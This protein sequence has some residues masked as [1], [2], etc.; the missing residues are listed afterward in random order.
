VRTLGPAF[1]IALAA[2]AALAFVAERRASAQRTRAVKEQALALGEVLRGAALE[3]DQALGGAEA[4]LAGRLGA[5]ARRAETLLQQGR[6]P[7]ADALQRVAK[8]ERVGRIALL[9]DRGQVTALVRHP[10]LPPAPGADLALR[11]RAHAL[12]REDLAAAARELAPPPG[13]V[14]TEGLAS[15]RLAAR[16]RFG[17]AYGR[18]DGGTLLLRADADE[19]AELRRRFGLAAVLARVADQP[20]VVAARLLGPRHEVLLAE[21]G[22]APRADPPRGGWPSAAS[23]HD[24]EAGARALVPF[25]LAD[26]TALT[27]DLTLSSAEADAALEASR[28]VV[29]LGAGLGAAALAGAAVWLSSR[30]RARRR[31]EQRAALARE[32]EARLAEMG[33]LAGLVT[34]ELSNPLNAVR[35]GLS[36]LET[37][38]PDVRSGVLGA[39]KGEAARMGRTLESFLGLARAPSAARG[40]LGPEVLQRVRER[41]AQQAEARGVRVDVS[42][43]PGAPRAQGDP[44]VLEQALANLVRNAV[45]ASPPAGTVRVSWDT[46]E[47]GAVRVCVDDEGPGFPPEDRDALLRVGASGR[48]GGHGLGLPLAERFV[49]QH[50]GR[51]ALLDRPGGG[52]RVEVRLKTSGGLKPGEGPHHG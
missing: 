12:E 9:D 52:A 24:V 4:H 21:A 10:D 7:A 25:T 43:P 29:L 39:L 32:D 35:L 19:L 2:L 28:R 33:A 31:A 50:G 49:R 41:T 42:A 17:V 5:A 38:G 46:A 48:P 3:A 30:E 16:E 20:G 26:G 45:D 44:L 18:P 15:S 34:H 11:E 37:A 22:E 1:L 47:D 13:Q 8:E 40:T 6:A 36:V 14:R 23:A 27:V 51:L